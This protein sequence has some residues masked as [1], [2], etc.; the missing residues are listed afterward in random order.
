MD[1]LKLVD[2]LR[3]KA[4]I[5]YEEAKIALEN[6][7]WDILEAMLYL[8]KHGKVNSPSVSI[9]YSNEYRESYT[10][11]E[12]THNNDDNINSDNSKSKDNFEGIFE[13][14]CKVID[15]GNNIFLQVKKSNRVLV[16]IP[17]TVVVVL[18]FF[19]FWVII[20]L[21]IVALFF[22]IEISLFSKRFDTDKIDKVNEA[23]R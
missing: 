20:P 2:R 17:L 14:I 21:I 23:F 7:N 16:K 22:D 1:K 18:L 3:E 5:S 12:E 8:E 6:S 19:A 11:H 9:F 10:E 15:T 13:A 4:N